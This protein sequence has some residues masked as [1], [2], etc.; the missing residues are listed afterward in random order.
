LPRMEHFQAYFAHQVR[1][2]RISSVHVWSKHPV[3]GG[4]CVKQL[5]WAV[6]TVQV[7]EILRAQ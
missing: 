4:I 5:G 1:V 7:W 3:P 6:P 2:C